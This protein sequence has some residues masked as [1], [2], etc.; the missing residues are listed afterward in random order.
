M[1]DSTKYIK[2]NLPLTEEEYVAG[3]GEGVWVEVDR[4]TKSA[5]DRD[6]I[7]KG[8]YG[9]LSND[10]IYYPGLNRGV[11]LPFE[12]RGENRPVADFLG[13]LA[14]RPH[15]TANGKAAVIQKIAEQ[16]VKN[17]IDQE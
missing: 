9:I 13:F 15:L 5:F 4:Q 1:F 17:K 2:I 7:G 14:T 8:F 6:A 11:V 3:N 10:S 12:L 16:Q